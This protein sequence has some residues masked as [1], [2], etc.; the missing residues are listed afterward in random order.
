MLTRGRLLDTVSLLDGG[1]MEY[2][3]AV[4]LC[5]NPHPGA[6]KGSKRTSRAWEQFGSNPKY[7]RH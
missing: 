6:W 2:S 4:D 3:Q 5:H 1:L 7:R